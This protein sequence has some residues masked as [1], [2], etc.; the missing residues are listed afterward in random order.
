MLMAALMWYTISKK[1]IQHTECR[2]FLAELISP[3]FFGF[4]HKLAAGE[5]GAPTV[6]PAKQQFSGPPHFRKS[7]PN[8]SA[9]V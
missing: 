5:V 1:T 3:S 6:V 2:L 8:T 9:L 7:R 4:E